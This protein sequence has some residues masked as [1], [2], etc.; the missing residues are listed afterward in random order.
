MKKQLRTIVLIGTITTAS[1]TIKGQVTT[2][3]NSGVSTDYVGWNS[4]QTFPV[5]VEHKG[6]YPINF[7]TNGTQKATILSNGN[8]GV[9]T[10]APANLLDVEGGV[11]I[12]AGYS[13]TS[14]APTN[15]LILEGRLGIGTPSPG[16]LF[17][18]KQE[19]DMRIIMFKGSATGSVLTLQTHNDAVSTLNPMGFRASDFRFIGGNVGIGT[20]TPIDRM[21]IENQTNTNPQLVLSSQ[22]S[23]GISSN[24]LIGGINFYSNDPDLQGASA[25][26]NTYAE[27]TH[28]ASQL[29]SRLVFSTTATSSTTP[30]ERMRIDKDG[31]LGINT[32]A[33]SQKLE[34]KDGNILLSNSGTAAEMRFAEPGG[35]DYTS[36]KAVAQTSNINYT[37]PA[38]QGATGTYLKNDGSGNLTWATGPVGAT[39]ATGV[40]GANGSNGTT[41]ATGP[42]GATGTTGVVGATGADGSANA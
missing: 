28:N 18:L 30:S 27:G 25:L 22:T 16:Y 11:A 12:G 17:D 35:T 4:S 21:T 40:A 5:L 24:E 19:T 29:P 38:A 20:I 31:N 32:T 33:P 13:G 41:G 7:S 2:G 9:G 10:T 34:V 36:F 26:I 14:T 39:G 23:N 37:L 3:F 15:G 8:F 1:L 6:A 42:T